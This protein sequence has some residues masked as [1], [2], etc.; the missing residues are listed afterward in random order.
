MTA[1][2]ITALR[3]A[4]TLAAFHR[5]RFEQ[6]VGDRE[7]YHQHMAQRC[8]LD[9]EDIKRQ[10]AAAG[11]T[12][13]NHAAATCSCDLA[14]AQKII[15]RYPIMHGIVMAVEDV[16]QARVAMAG[17]LPTPWPPN[18]A[19]SL[20]HD[21]GASIRRSQPCQPEPRAHAIAKKSDDTGI[22]LI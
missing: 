9:A 19:G 12:V 14:T 17:T 18:G 10:L 5:Q 2:L 4:E 22:G 7:G 21:I 15:D 11:V 8:D 13:E 3:A 16:G 20:R 1:M 6:T